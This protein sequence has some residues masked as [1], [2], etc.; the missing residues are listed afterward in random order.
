MY[1]LNIFR[2]L[3]ALVITLAFSTTTLAQINNT[4]YGR[5]AGSSFTSGSYNSVYGGSSGQFTTT[6]SRNTYLGSHSGNRN[7]SGNQ[8]LFAGMYSG[9]Y[10]NYGSANVYLGYASGFKN[11]GDNNT[12]LGANSGFSSTN[13]SYNVLLGYK[14]GYE[15]RAGY[16]N[17]FIGSFAGYKNYGGGNVFIGYRA[18]YDETGSNKLYIANSN[19]TPLIYG[20][21]N[22]ETVSIGGKNTGSFYKLTV[23]GNTYTTGSYISSDKRLK[24]KIKPVKGAMTRLQKIEGVTYE[25]EQ[26]RYKER[27]LPEG[28]Q[29]GLL[30]QNVQSIFPDLVKEDE[31]GYLAVNYDGMIP[32]IIE[33]L[34]EISQGQSHRPAQ[35]QEQLNLLM[36][37]NAVLQQRLTAIEQVL[38]QNN[39]TPSVT[40]L[41][42]SLHQ[43]RPNPVQGSSSIAY[44]TAPQARSVSIKVYNLEGQQVASFQNLSA[45]QGEVQL[46]S[47]QLPAGTYIYHLIVDGE[48]IDSKRMLVAQ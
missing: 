38:Q 25:Y 46:Q 45:G 28:A 41:Q 29:I 19:E 2:T 8:N 20:D 36:K 32:V 40:G 16:Y 31:E 14:S 47:Q 4:R 9:A 30:A 22:K 21:F 1:N 17:T 33:A 34:K 24:K 44:Q 39:L 43:N 23:Y 5:Y 15:N 27:N 3:Q 26:A 11:N 6:G 48:A 18:G 12:F 13:G 7:A 37:E 10:G 35:S 42:G